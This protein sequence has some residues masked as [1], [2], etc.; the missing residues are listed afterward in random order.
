MV[1]RG[2]LIGVFLSS[3][4]S[5]LQFDFKAARNII[6][7]KDIAKELI[8][9]SFKSLTRMH[10]R[11]DQSEAKIFG[12]I[13][14][15]ISSGTGH[16]KMAAATGFD[17]N[18]PVTSK[19]KVRSSK[20]KVQSSSSFNLQE[21][22]PSHYFYHFNAHLIFTVFQLK[23]RTSLTSPLGFQGYTTHKFLIMM[24][25]NPFLLRF[26]VPRSLDCVLRCFSHFL[27]S[28]LVEALKTYDSLP[29]STTSN[30]SFRS[31]EHVGKIRETQGHETLSCSLL[32]RFRFLSLLF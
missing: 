4:T 1:G 29:I 6:L 12:R 5:I 31:V 10:A 8:C 13:A 2:H 24:F 26:Q 22:P 14:I 25:G 19:F 21:K 32:P 17:S 20:F 30:A 7:R 16:V 9:F 28:L 3:A 15:N 11:D 23:V 27:N 18:H